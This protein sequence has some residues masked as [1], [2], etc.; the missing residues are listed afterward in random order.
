MAVFSKQTTRPFDISFSSAFGL[1]Y[2]QVCRSL[3][4][5]GHPAARSPE[6]HIFTV[7]N[8]A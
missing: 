3:L 6:R 4:V 7:Q 1:G 2:G 8:G 5:L